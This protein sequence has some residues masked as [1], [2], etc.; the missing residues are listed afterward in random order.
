LPPPVNLAVANLT[1]VPFTNSALQV[2]AT[3]AQG[4]YGDDCARVWAFWGG[5]DG[6]TA[7]G[8]WEHSQNL[9][10]NTRFNPATFTALLTN[11]APQT[12]CFFR[13]YAT[14]ASGEAWAPASAQ[15][16]M[17]SNFSCRMRIAFTGYNRGEPLANFPVLVNLRASLS[18]FSYRQFASPAGGDL[19]FADANGLRQ[20]PYEVDQ[21]DTNGTSSLWVQVPQLASTNDSIWAYWG[22]PAATNPPAWTTNGSVW[23]PDHL[24]VWHLKESG[25]PYADSARQH[26]ALSGTAPLST[27]GVV[28]RGC[29]FNG[30]SHY[31]DAGLIN[32]GNA[33]TLSAW[34]KPDPSATNIQTIW[35]NK[36]GGWNSDGFA[37]Y[38]NSYQTCDRALI[39][40]TGNGATGL[41]AATPTN[42]VSPGQWHHLAASVDLAA[43]ARLF[44]DGTDCTQAGAIRS[45]L[46]NHNSVNLGRFTDGNFSF[47]GTM[48]EVRIEAGTRSSNWLWASWM[49][50]AS[51][52]TFASCSPVDPTPAL[53]LAPSGDGL[54]LT[55]PVGAGVC[56]LYMTTSLAAPVAWLPATNLPALTNGQWRA[57]LGP[58]TSGSRFYR[59]QYW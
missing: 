6:G 27:P 36:A 16:L 4:V 14:N 57:P 18:G 31:L 22:N 54:L 23:S 46:A 15:L 48:D 53:S 9:G 45:D 5:Q 34:V 7:R 17:P 25:F 29:S 8:A 51:N 2:S 43:A 59:L 42:A 32:L 26:P 19:R 47:T 55:W 38:L 10:L 56:T 3:L 28:G 1:A 20:L 40:E 11:L 35:A 50:V 33:F 30:A 49:T 12:N 44:V 13:F 21:W 37:L 58:G 24:L 52:A 41:D 39:L